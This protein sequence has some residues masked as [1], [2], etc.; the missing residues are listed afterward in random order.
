M[1]SVRRFPIVKDESYKEAYLYQRNVDSAIDAFCTEIDHICE[2]MDL[3]NELADAGWKVKVAPF[4]DY[5][6]LQIR[7]KRKVKTK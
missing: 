5:P 2:V 3:A 4:E 6:M 1:L 7:A